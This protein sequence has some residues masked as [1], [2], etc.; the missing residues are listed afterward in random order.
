MSSIAPVPTPAEVLSRRR[1]AILDRDADGFAAL[2]APDGVID[3]P[4]AGT[5]DAPLRIEGRPAI[6]QLAR[7]LM[8]SRMSVEEF[9]VT[10]F[11]QTRDPEVVIVEARTKGAVTATG[12]AFSVTS[13]QVFQIRDGLITLFRDFADPRIVADVLGEHP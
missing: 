7:Q 8:D 13:I 5:P 12:R 2:F 1:Q 4:F 3:L 9:E 11:H 6:Q 10:A